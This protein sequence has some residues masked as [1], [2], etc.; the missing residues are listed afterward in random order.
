MKGQKS[1]F[2][3]KRR[4]SSDSFEIPNKEWMLLKKDI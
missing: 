4:L 3:K 2:S 1:I